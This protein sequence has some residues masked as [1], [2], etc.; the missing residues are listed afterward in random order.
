MV[1]HTLAV[2]FFTVS[3]SLIKP[4][5]F[6]SEERSHQFAG[7]EW[8]VQIPDGVEVARELAEDY[9]LRVVK[10]VCENELTWCLKKIIY[11]SSTNWFFF[12]QY[13]NSLGAD[14][15][16]LRRESDLGD[17]SRQRRAAVLPET[18]RPLPSDPRVRSKLDDFIAKRSN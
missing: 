1:L 18:T 13:H 8:L 4:S 2:I 14:I 11:H 9:G 16:L 6:A 7:Y 3:A 5:I 10:Q 12:L 15:Y 17:S